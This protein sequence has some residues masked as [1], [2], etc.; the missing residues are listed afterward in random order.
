MLKSEQQ[1]SYVYML[2]TIAIPPI[3]AFIAMLPTPVSAESCYF[4]G[5]DPMKC[6]PSWSYEDNAASVRIIW[7]DGIK[8]TYRFQNYNGS[9]A[10]LGIALDPRGG[11]WRLIDK[12]D[13]CNWELK[14]LSNGN[15]IRVSRCR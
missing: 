1:Q 11:R 3:A 14:N 8:E 6:T 5:K 4:N 13:G 15:V 7:A 2:R 12:R 9:N 10:S